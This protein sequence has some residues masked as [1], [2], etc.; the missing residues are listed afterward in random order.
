M[1]RRRRRKLVRAD[2]K[3]RLV[4]LLREKDEVRSFVRIQSAVISFMIIPSARWFSSVI[5]VLLIAGGMLSF[6]A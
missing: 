5:S 1:Q 4:L 2:D 6:Y 3:D